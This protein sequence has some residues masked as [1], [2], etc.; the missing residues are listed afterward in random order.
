LPGDL[1]VTRD[2]TA[3]SRWQRLVNASWP[4]VRTFGV[5]VRVGWTVLLVPFVLFALFHLPSRWD[6]GGVLQGWDSLLA[7]ELAIGLTAALYATSWFHEMA[8]VLVGRRFGVLTRVIRLSPVGGL[9]HAEA[10]IASPRVRMWTALAGPFAQVALVVAL[11]VPFLAAD[12][13]LVADTQEWARVYEW[14]L[15]WHVALLALNLAPAWPLDGGR[16][17]RGALARAMH[18]GKASFWTAQLGLAAALVLAILGGGILYYG[19]QVHAPTPI[20]A[21]ALLVLCGVNGFFASRHLHNAAPPVATPFE[22][23]A[24]WIPAPVGAPDED[25]VAESGRLARAEQRRERRAAD[26]RRQEAEHRQRLQERI[27]ELLDRINEVGGVENLSA[28]ERREL[29]EA[30]ETL[31]SEPVEN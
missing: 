16:F 2:D 12:L 4:L 1:A 3:P 10:A 6:T 26:A 20:C 25:S 9:G 22:A 28:E 30:S 15:V 17:L 7:A 8:H 31:R 29:A 13:D 5:E 21:G 19:L 23:K 11:G 24:S 14:F 27:D 18:E